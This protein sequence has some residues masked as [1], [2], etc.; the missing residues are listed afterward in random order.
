MSADEVEKPEES[1][2]GPAESAAGDVQRHGAP[3]ACPRCGLRL[4]QRVPSLAVQYCPR[5]LARARLAVQLNRF[6]PS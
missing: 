1:S 3:V 4:T 5:C 6:D 2:A